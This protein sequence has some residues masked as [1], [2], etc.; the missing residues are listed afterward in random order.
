ML[1]DMHSTEQM[2]GL[3]VYQHGVN[4]HAEYKKLI[5]T[6]SAGTCTEPVL[7]DVYNKVKD[8][9]LEPETIETYQI[10]HDCGKPYCR[11]VDDEGKVHFPDHANVSA[12]VFGSVFPE[13]VQIKELIRMDMAWHTVRG[14]DIAELW[15]HPYAGTLYLTAWAEILANCQMFGGTDSTSFKI[16]RKKLVQCG[17]KMP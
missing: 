11:S 6:L 9:L 8:T 10:Y 14:D 15:K 7:Q 12:E 4:V 1:A 2:K 16:K 3:S 5:Q 17:K 13:K